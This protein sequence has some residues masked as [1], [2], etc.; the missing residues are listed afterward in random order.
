VTVNPVADLPSL[1]VS[2][3]TGNEDS[4]IALSITTGL[5]DTDGSETLSIAVTGVPNGAVLSAGTTVLSPINGVWMRIPTQSG[6]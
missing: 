6:R 5:L 2:A 3:A 4:A 1:S